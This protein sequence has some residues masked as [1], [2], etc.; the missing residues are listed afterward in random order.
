VSGLPVAVRWLLAI[1]VVLISGFF[2]GERQGGEWRGSARS[3]HAPPPL[4]LSHPLSHTLSQ[5]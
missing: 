3:A 1:V 4:S 5:A 2:A